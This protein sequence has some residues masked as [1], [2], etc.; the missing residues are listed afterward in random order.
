MWLSPSASMVM[1]TTM[2]PAGD[3]CISWDITCGS[4]STANDTLLVSNARHRLPN[5]SRPV[6]STLKGWPTRCT[7][8]VK[9]LMQHD[10]GLSVLASAS[11]SIGHPGTHS[12]STATC[13]RWV[14]A[15]SRVM[16]AANLDPG[17]FSQA[18]R[19]TVPEGD[20]ALI[21]TASS[22]LIRWPLAYSSGCTYTTSSSPHVVA[23]AELSRL[24]SCKSNVVSAAPLRLKATTHCLA[25]TRP[26]TAFTLAG[27]SRTSTPSTVT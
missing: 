27:R 13:R 4:G 9:P 26:C 18:G 16:R 11:K 14:P 7:T 21:V 24:T 23:G 20:T 12:P 15:S 8:F 3:L 10:V 5:A 17:A 25:Y 1:V 19:S 2:P 22:P 6:T